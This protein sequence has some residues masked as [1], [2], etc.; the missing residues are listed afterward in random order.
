VQ[1]AFPRAG[2]VY[3][4]GECWRARGA[5]PAPRGAGRTGYAA[6]NA[7]RTGDAA[8]NAGRGTRSIGIPTHKRDPRAETRAERVC[9]RGERL[10]AE[11][12]PGSRNAARGIRP[13][14]TPTHKRDPR[15]ET[16]AE[17]VCARGERL[18]ARRAAPRRAGRTGYAAR[19]AWRTGYAARNAGRGIRSI[20]VARINAIHAQKHV[21]NAFARAE[22]VYARGER[23]RL[24]AGPDGPATR[25]G[26]PGGP[27]MRRGTP[28]A[29]SCRSASRTHKR[30]PRAETRAER[31]CARGERLCAR[32]A[33]PRRAG[34]TGYAARNAWRTADAARNAGRGIRSI[35]IPT[36]KH[37]PRSETR[38]GS[39]YA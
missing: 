7:W 32:R 6:R 33:S 9:A 22:S 14:G 28:V 23:F 3:A 10:C 29:A 5:F 15:T 37:D 4:R 38:A 36:H 26:T 8:R 24:R 27:P 1:S 2:S 19:N 17:R 25:P 20:G 35:G 21:Q 16:R 30:N 11:S 13:I 39:V 34:R 12:V 18:C 31:V